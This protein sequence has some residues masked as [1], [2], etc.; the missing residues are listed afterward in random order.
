MMAVGWLVEK[1]TEKLTS[2]SPVQGKSCGE[3]MGGEVDKRINP[4][5]DH[6]LLREVA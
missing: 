3:R 4:R 5:H 2:P 6:K 1:S